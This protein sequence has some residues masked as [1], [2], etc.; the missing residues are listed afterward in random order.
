[1]SSGADRFKHESLQDTETIVQYLNALKEGLQ[2][3]TLALT[4]DDH[5]LLLKPQGL[6]NLDVEAKRKGDEVKL[7]IKLRWNEESRSAGGRSS[8]LKIQ[9]VS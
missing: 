8:A 2:G 5:R 1:M 3:G 6:I 4:S 9:P 7:V